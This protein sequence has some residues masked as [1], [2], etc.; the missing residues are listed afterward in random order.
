MYAVN[1]DKTLI[2]LNKIKENILKGKTEEILC[3]E[4]DN[5]FYLGK[6]S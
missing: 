1:A 6:L 2:H 5:L 4:T 3:P